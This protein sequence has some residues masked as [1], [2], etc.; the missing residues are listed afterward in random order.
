MSVCRAVSS[1]DRWPSLV[2]ALS[3]V[4][5]TSELFGQERPPIRDVTPSGIGRV[6]QSLPSAS[7]TAIPPTEKFSNARLQNDGSIFAGGKVLRLR[8]IT[9]PSRT[10][11][12]GELKEMRWACGVRAH[13]ALWLALEKKT[14]ECEQTETPADS[15]SPVNV[16][17]WIERKD[18]ALTLLERGWAYLA[19][20]GE[21]RKTYL[22]AAAAAKANHAGL[23]S[24]GAPE[25]SNKPKRP[26]A[27][28]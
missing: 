16:T 8:G 19:D 25:Q 4:L 28:P 15:R 9:L 10:K 13:A 3:L 27:I 24:E 6:F 12:C 5:A 26:L 23:W 21:D 18:L 2:I 20:T 22:A 7:A 14:L 17:C 11:I 1:S